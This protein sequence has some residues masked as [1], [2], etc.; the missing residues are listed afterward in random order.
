MANVNKRQYFKFGDEAIQEINERQQY[1]CAHCGKHLGHWNCKTLGSYH[2]VV[3]V[4]AGNP[5]DPDDEFIKSAD[6]GVLLCDRSAK[7]DE[8]EVESCH[9]AVAHGGGR[10]RTFVAY[11]S[12]FPF[13]HGGDIEEHEAWAQTVETHFRRLSANLNSPTN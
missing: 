11:A 5:A 7:I 12:E 8:G 1:R 2:H 9:G 4:Q 13:S 10:Y 3:P 6:N